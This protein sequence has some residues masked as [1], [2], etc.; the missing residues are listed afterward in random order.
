[1]EDQLKEKMKVVMLPSNKNG[2]IFKQFNNLYTENELQ[3]STATLEERKIIPQHLHVVSKRNP[4]AGEWRYVYNTKTYRFY[5]LNPVTT[6]LDET[7]ELLIE[8]TTDKSLKLPLISEKFVKK[9]AELNGIDEVMVDM[10]Y[11]GMINTKGTNTVELIPKVDKNN[12]ITITKVKENWTKKELEEV[13]RNI[14][15]SNHIEWIYARMK[16]V[17]KEDENYD[18]MIKLK[19]VVDFINNEIF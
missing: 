7:Q 17:H 2:V 5:K 11:S 13:F 12:Y 19:K 8:A 3:K 6:K 18:Y 4:E 15:G 14:N 1:M 9:Y 10:L 16:N